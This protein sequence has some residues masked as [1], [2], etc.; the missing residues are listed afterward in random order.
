VTDPADPATWRRLIKWVII[1]RH[2]YRQWKAGRM[3]RHRRGPLL[4]TPA[5]TEPRG[6][7]PDHGD[8]PPRPLLTAEQAR[9]RAYWR[10]KLWK[11]RHG[12]GN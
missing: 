11:D 12:V 1:G 2:M 4:I 9:L 10:L 7:F 8:E 3:G 6:E 5:R